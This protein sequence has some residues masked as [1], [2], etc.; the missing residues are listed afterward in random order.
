MNEE[1]ISE[2]CELNKLIVDWVCMSMQKR[3]DTYDFAF[4]GQY[5]EKWP[6]SS[7]FARRGEEYKALTE[8]ELIDNFV[9]YCVRNQLGAIHPVTKDGSVVFRLPNGK[10]EHF[11]TFEWLALMQHHGV[12]TRLVDFT[13]NPYIALFFSMQ[14]PDNWEGPE[15]NFSLYVLKR[16]HRKKSNG[17][18]VGNKLPR[19]SAGN[20]FI[21]ERDSKINMNVFLGKSIGLDSFVKLDGKWEHPT[22][23]WGWDCPAYQN[24]RLKRQEG[25]FVYQAVIK[26]EPENLGACMNAD[27]TKYTISHKLRS[28]IRELTHC[29]RGDYLFPDFANFKYNDLS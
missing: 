27:L 7:S 26:S 14:K 15:P 12:P 10:G 23:N 17:T 28:E 22:Q 18:E 13:R 4:R 24:E 20:H 2:C 3:V 25:L 1:I 29:L 9:R 16:E 5:D 21:W 19:D 6:L 11:D 8:K